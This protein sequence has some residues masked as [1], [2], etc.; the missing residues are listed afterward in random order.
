MQRWTSKNTSVHGLTF[1]KTL[2]PSLY[3]DKL[4]TFGLPTRPNGTHTHVPRFAAHF[5]NLLHVLS[6]ELKQ[7]GPVVTILLT[8]RH[9]G[10]PR[11]IC[12]DRQLSLGQQ[13]PRQDM[14]LHVSGLAPLQEMHAHQ[15]L[16]HLLVIECSV[17]FAEEH[18]LTNNLSVE[19]H[20][21]QMREHLV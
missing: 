3:C 12:P 1:W 16:D 11:A 10:F 13:S 8:E 18:T 6:A 9:K 15:F 7:H 2:F 17:S 21:S 20:G 5:G 19:R 14:I 4:P